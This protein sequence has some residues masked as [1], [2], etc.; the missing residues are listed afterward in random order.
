MRYIAAMLLLAGLAVPAVAAESSAPATT[1]TSVAVTGWRLECGSTATAVSCHL[2][3]QIVQASNGGLV[4]GFTLAPASD[5]KDVLTILV[6]LDASLRTPIALSISG[7][8]SQSF[9]YATCSQQGCYAIG[10]VN[11]DLLNAMRSGKGDLHVTYGLLDSNLVEHGI[12]ASLSLTG[13]PEVY[14]RLK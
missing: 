1:S 9:S 3:D 13:F 7:G 10:P 4:I 6:P 11:G 14:A 12:N 8:P 5:G 2:L